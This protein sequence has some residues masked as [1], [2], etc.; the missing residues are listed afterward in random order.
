LKENVIFPVEVFQIGLMVPQA[1]SPPLAAI[2]EVMQL[3][4]HDMGLGLPIRGK[5][6]QRTTMLSIRELVYRDTNYYLILL[7]VAGL[8][9]RTS[10][11]M[12][13]SSLG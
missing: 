9:C 6:R 7:L 11:A 3:T 5:C 10:L 13:I 8:N 1:G 12:R 4:R 2:S